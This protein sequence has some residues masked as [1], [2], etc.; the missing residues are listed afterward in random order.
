MIFILGI[1]SLIQIVF[2]P[3]LILLKIFNLRKGVIQAASFIF[4]LSLV[5]NFTWV[6]LLASLKINYSILHYMLFTIEIGLVF[7]LYRKQLFESLENIAIDIY[8]RLNEMLSKL[9]NFFQRE[10]QETAFTRIIKSLIIIIFFIWA[11]SSLLWISKLYIVNLGT[12]FK[13]WDAVV[14]WNRWAGEWFN[15]TIPSPNRYSQLIPANFS[16]TY[17]FLRSTDIQIFAKSIMPLF[18][19]FTWSLMID[20]AFE[21][22]NPGIFI[23]VVILR[24][25]TKNFLGQY[26]GEGYVDVALLFFSFLSVYTLLKASNSERGSKKLDYIYLGTI[27]AAGTA[28]TKQNGLLIF[29]FYPLLAFLLMNDKIN[30]AS[31]WEKS[32]FLIKP[33]IIGLLVLLPWYLLNE[34]RILL[35][36]NSTNVEYLISADRHSGRTYWERVT[37]AVDMLEIYKYLFVLVII[38]LPLI[39]KKF[40]QVGLIMIFPYTIIWVFL[41]SI[42]T[43]NLAMVFPFLALTA[44]LGMYGLGDYFLRLIQKLKFQRL[45]GIFFI[46]LLVLVLF[47]SSLFFTNPKLNEMQL[48]DQKNALL[49]NLNQELYNYFDDRG[50]YGAIMTQYP[51]NYLPYLNEYKI[52]EP[53]SILKEF[54]ENFVAH[55]EAEYFLVWDKYASKEVN[56]QLELFKDEGVIEFLFEKYNMKFYKVKDREAILNAIPD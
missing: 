34:S 8:A 4:G 13:Q 54:Y 20:L 14:S 37:R 26:I 29:V 28:L 32:R 19:I 41:F 30:L 7:W 11:V 40:R 12:A 2:L 49:S 16:I 17:S 44:G 56:D 55:P 31:I 45:Q 35:G 27:F 1:L 47:V 52:P 38:T 10:D 15:N 36:L 51:I 48:S 50:E 53:F 21:Y 25:M 43:R 46:S 5:F 9:R 6:L 39:P 3:G 42:F 33:M 23:G 18:T 24:Y 22:K